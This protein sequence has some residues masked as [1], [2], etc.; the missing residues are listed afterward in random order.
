VFDEEH[1]TSYLFTL[2]EEGGIWVDAA[3]YG[4]LSRY[5]NHA[6]EHDKKGCNITPKIM[7][8]NHEFRIKFTALRDIK[9]GEELFFNY[10][11][12][13]PNL[14]KKLLEQDEDKP[15]Q[16][17]EKRK[18]GT[19]RS[20]A[21]ARKTTKPGGKGKGKKPAVFDEDDPMDWATTGVPFEDEFADDWEEEHTPKR[22]KKRGGRRPGAGRKKKVVVEDQNNQ[23]REVPDSQDDSSLPPPSVSTDTPIRSGRIRGSST[24][25]G[26]LAT[27]RPNKPA[28]E[29]PVK[30]VSKRGGARPGAGRKPKHPKA[31]KTT[32]EGSVGN[33]GSSASSSF[34]TKPTHATTNNAVE[35]DGGRS[36]GLLHDRISS[37]A[38]SGAAETTSNEPNRKRKANE[39]IDS[40]EE[41]I[42]AG[43]TLRGGG[44]GGGPYR[45]DH[46]QPIDDD[47]DDDDAVADRPRKRQKPL[48][49]RHEQI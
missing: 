47:D 38:A 13:F 6:S 42:M 44:G 16:S 24:N 8:V 11:D 25:P 49:Y 22:R 33:G 30:K 36:R 37:S 39:L 28:D 14:T 21:A 18:T 46:F 34:A 1:T 43:S 7:Y 15:G 41:E 29:P 48:R 19:Q 27:T 3:I 4:N 20:D 26:A 23:P 10:G 32:L 45:E 31:A 9:A 12:N 35:E 17:S 2:L 5:I 40:G